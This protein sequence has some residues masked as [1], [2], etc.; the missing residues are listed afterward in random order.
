MSQ[1]LQVIAFETKGVPFSVFSLHD[2]IV[3]HD[4][5]VYYPSIRF[6]SRTNIGISGLQIIEDQEVM[7]LESSPLWSQWN[8]LV[9]SQELLYI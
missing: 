3:F 2:P 1:F 9:L 4:V 7:S 6:W 5:V 8:C